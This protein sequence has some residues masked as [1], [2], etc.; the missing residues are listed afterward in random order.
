MRTGVLAKKLGMTRIF[1]EEGQHVPV[2]VLHVDGC[3]VVA[4]RTE[5]KDGYSAVQLGV[6]KAKAKNVPKPMREH[7]AK[8]KVAPKANVG[9]FR[10]SGDALLEPG[11]ELSAS[12]FVPGQFVDA[13]GITIGR[14][15]QGAIKRHNFG[16]Q[17]AS[18]GV[19]AVHRS[20]GSTGQMQDPGKVFKGKKMPGQ[21][22]NRKVTTQNLKVVSID[23]E[24]NLL[25]VRG[26]I[27]GHDGSWVRITDAI[28]RQLPENAPFP[29]GLRAAAESPDG[30]AA[31]AEEKK[32]Q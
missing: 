30:D 21:M 31:P 28:K 19:S 10:V 32:D 15:F 29:A 4:V 24:R 23:E 3:Q 17:R 9:E 5:E 20:M 11:Q 2:T 27:P 14:G 1:T 26:N 7:F 12:H 13:S 25:L 8:A 16:G 18:H 22:G 6:G